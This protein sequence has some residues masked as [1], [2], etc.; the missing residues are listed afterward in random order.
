LREQLVKEAAR[1]FSG[2]VEKSAPSRARLKR[3]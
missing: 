3:S 1:Y 2:K